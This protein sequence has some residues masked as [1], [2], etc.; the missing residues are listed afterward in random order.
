MGVWG[1]DAGDLMRETRCW[2]RDVEAGSSGGL[3]ARCRS[4]KHG[5]MELWRRAAVCND[6]QA[7]R[8]EGLEEGSKCSD[9]ELLEVAAVGTGRICRSAK[10]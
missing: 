4:A 1:L 8:Y 9:T 5:G 7:W 3:E 2:C 10:L 6:V